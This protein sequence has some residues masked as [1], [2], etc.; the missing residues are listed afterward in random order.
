MN[1]LDFVLIAILVGS[2]VSS[3]SKGFA[4]EVIGLIAAVAALVCGAWFY[5]MAGEVVR[6]WVGSREVANLCGFLLI[7]A[8]VIV[9]G[10]VV[11]WILGAMMKA[12]GLSWLDRLLGAG[13]GVARGVIVCV[14]VIT[15]IVAFAPGRDPKTPPRAVV[16]SKIAPYMIDTAHALTTAAPK[17]LRVE[18]ALVLDD[19]APEDARP[20]VLLLL[21]REVRPKNLLERVL[22]LGLLERVVRSVVGHRLVIRRFPGQLLDLLVG[23]RH[24]L[25]AH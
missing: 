21:H 23:F 7:L 12:V 13:F 20:R 5:R 8:A 1:W 22:L 14:A 9:L 17:E 4:R 2:V 19:D 10:W 11:S 16:D 24:T 18:F 3:V 15:A 25:T 6:P